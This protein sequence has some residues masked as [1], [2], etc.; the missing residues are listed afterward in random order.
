MTGKL[1][2]EILIQGQGLRGIA[3]VHW[4]GC[5]AAEGSV[6]RKGAK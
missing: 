1:W 5:E 2:Q 6:M 4:A 3:A